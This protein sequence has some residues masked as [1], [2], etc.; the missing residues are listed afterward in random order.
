MLK[1]PS[2]NFLFSPLPATASNIA[3]KGY[4]NQKYPIL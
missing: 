2:A 3:I 1:R 4:E